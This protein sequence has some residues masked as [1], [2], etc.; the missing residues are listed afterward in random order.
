MASLEISFLP[1]LLPFLS[2]LE[3]DQ[4]VTVL[5]YVER[6]GWAGD[7][8]YPAALISRDQRGRQSRRVNKLL[9]LLTAWLQGESSELPLVWEKDFSSDGRRGQDAKPGLWLLGE[10]DLWPQGIKEQHLM[11]DWTLG[12]RTSYFSFSIPRAGL[13]PY[14]TSYDCQKGQ[15]LN[16]VW[17]PASLKKFLLWLRVF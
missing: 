2:L 7:C 11:R 13:Q 15:S 6:R 9:R 12:K 8:S 17:S 14:P 1:A 16:S 4:T 10:W 3:K 5:V